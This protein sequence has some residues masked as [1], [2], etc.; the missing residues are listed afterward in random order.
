LDLSAAAI[1]SARARAVAAGLPVTLEQADLDQPLPFAA[2]SFDAVMSVDVILHLHDRC[3]AFSEVARVLAPGGRFLFTDG[4]VHCAKCHSVMTSS[5]T[6][7]RGKRYRYY[8]CT[9]PKRRGTGECPIRNV[10]ADKLEAFV[11]ARIR[12]I[13]HDPALLEETLRAI[14][15]DRDAE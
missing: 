4:L 5:F 11:V 15:A 7:P 10:S 13:G 14:E 12:D 6:A 3:S 8:S 2:G 1:A 9:A